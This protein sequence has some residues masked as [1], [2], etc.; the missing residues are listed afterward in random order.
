MRPLHHEKSET[1]IRVAEEHVGHPRTDGR[2][3]AQPL[4]RIEG[5]PLAGAGRNVGTAVAASR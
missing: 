4:S 2:P 5:E 1:L 3:G